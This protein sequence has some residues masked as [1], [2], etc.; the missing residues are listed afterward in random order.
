VADYSQIEPRIAALIVRD[1]C[2]IEAFRGGED[3]HRAVS[4]PCLRKPA[5]EVTPEERKLGKAVNFG[6]LHGQGAEGF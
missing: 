5:L 1:R 4:A 3:L 2:I 6:F